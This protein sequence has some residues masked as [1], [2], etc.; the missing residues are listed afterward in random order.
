MN[1]QLN[2]GQQPTR[3]LPWAVPAYDKKK[4]TNPQPKM[5]RHVLS[6]EGPHGPD[7]NSKLR[8]GSWNVGSMVGRSM[9]IVDELRKRKVDVCCVQETRWSGGSAKS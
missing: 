5:R 4:G 6:Y 3:R 7:M 8:F 1:L 9:E 2:Y